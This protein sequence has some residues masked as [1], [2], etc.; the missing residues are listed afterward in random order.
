MI[1]Q[2][3]N[4][5][6]VTYYGKRSLEVLKEIK[7]E[8]I[9][10]VYSKSIEKNEEFQKIKASLINKRINWIIPKENTITEI[11]KT[12]KEINKSELIIAVGGGNI[13]DFS[14]LLRIKIN[15]PEIDLTQIKN[16]TLLEKNIDLIVIPSTPSTGSQV[17]PIAITHNRERKEKVIIINEGNIPELVILSPQL[18]ITISEKQM[19]E[20]ICDIFAHSIEAYLSRLT[21]IF[22]QDLAEMNLKKLVENWKI[23]REKNNDLIV[24]EKIAMNGQ[25]GG[26]CQG[27]AYVGVMHSIAHQLELLNG[28]SHSKA[29][30][31]II[32][33]V[34]EWYKK[35]TEKE[36]YTQFINYFDELEIESYKE[37]IFKGNIDEEEL[38]K[39]II[40]DPSIKT[41]PIIFN[42]EKVRDLVKWILMKK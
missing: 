19:A 1:S 42:E 16:I 29:L 40:S 27:N 4:K 20:F 38:I 9:T 37:D 8:D 26:I 7:K 15:N 22:V 21:N 3:L 23:Y 18:L 30:L 33:S 28:V 11:N 6:P 25:I 24:L 10:I 41:S 34:L 36:I 32:K 17:T 14:K 5:I 12:A 13:I 2:Y 31:H 39:K 35:E